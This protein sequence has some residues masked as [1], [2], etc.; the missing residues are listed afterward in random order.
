MRIA[1]FLVCASLA[2]ALAGCASPTAEL[3]AGLWHYK[4]G[5]FT[6]AIPRLVDA[7]PAMEA[8][9]PAD[10]QV[11]RAYLALGHMAS[12]EKA[13]P[14]IAEGY[15]TK[16]MALA[17]KYHAGNANLSRNAASETGNYYLANN[18]QARAL[19]FLLTAA[20]ISGREQV[21]PRRLHAIDLDNLS[22]AQAA[23]R[24]YALAAEYAQKHWTSLLRSPREKSRRLP[25]ALYFSIRLMHTLNK[26]WRPRQISYIANPWT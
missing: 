24:N 26:V 8:A 3:N 6:Q 7:V 1:H 4:A 12:A 14:G 25:A 9:H 19:P 22:V 23:L 15:F 11:L 10:P 18:Q 17:N 21:I 16:A 5:L 20:E 2:S 13:A